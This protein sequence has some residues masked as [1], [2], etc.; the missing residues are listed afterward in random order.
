[1]NSIV[2]LLPSLNP[3]PCTIAVTIFSCITLKLVDPNVTPRPIECCLGKLSTVQAWIEFFLLNG[4][5]LLYLYW[6]VGFRVTI[7]SPYN[8]ESNGKE[9]EMETGGI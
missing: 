6:G 3:Q 4:C 1:M 9:N 2:A 5:V 8:G 7:L